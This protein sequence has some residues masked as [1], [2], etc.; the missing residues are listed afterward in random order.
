MVDNGSI[1]LVVFE[2]YYALLCN[3][4]NITDHLI[5][6]FVE[7]KL[8]TAEEKESIAILEAPEKLRVLLLKILNALEA[9]DTGGFYIMLK[10]MRDHGDKGTKTLA[11]Q[12][13]SRLKGLS[14]NL[15][16]HIF[17]DDDVHAQDD[18]LEGCLCLILIMV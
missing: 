13:F 16:S 10:V 8:F 6:C 12:I 1:L 7:K 15:S 9:N 4:T 14:E 5:K 2:E 3:T 18:G 17:N 11:N